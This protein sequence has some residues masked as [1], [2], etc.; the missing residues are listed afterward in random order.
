MDEFWEIMI[1]KWETINKYFN[2]KIKPFLLILLI[3]SK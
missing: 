3:K 1:N 2:S